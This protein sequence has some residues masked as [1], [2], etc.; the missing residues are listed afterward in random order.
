MKQLAFKAK[1]KDI[2]EFFKDFSLEDVCI[3]ENDQGKS[4]G[5]AFVKFKNENEFYEALSMKKG[6]I[7]SKTF[8]IHRSDRDIQRP[9]REKKEE[10]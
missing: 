9:K 5:F 10:K 8:E 3:P 1:E 2:I 6:T 4:K 7:K